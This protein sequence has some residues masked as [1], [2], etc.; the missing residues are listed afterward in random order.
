M[1]RPE[2]AGKPWLPKRPLEERGESSRNREFHSRG[3]ERL[4]YKKS[5]TSRAVA[6]VEWKDAGRASESGEQEGGCRAT[7]GEPLRG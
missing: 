6:R 7:G 3:L 4:I 2:L 1:L 5:Y